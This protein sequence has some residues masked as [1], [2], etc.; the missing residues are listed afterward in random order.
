MCEHRAYTACQRVCG[1]VRTLNMAPDPR[2]ASG[3]QGTWGCDARAALRPLLRVALADCELRV[4]LWVL[5]DLKNKFFSPSLTSA[6]T[7][8]ATDN[9]EDNIQTLHT[10]S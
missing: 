6:L 1:R 5:G 2:A 10:P 8:P 3:E 9:F 4:C 7:P